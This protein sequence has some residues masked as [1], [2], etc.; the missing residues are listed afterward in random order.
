[1]SD[2]QR[3]AFIDLRV[4][5]HGLWILPIR[6][7]FQ[8][9][10]ESPAEHQNAAIALPKMLF[11]AIC[12]CALAGPCNEVLIHH[13]A[14]NPASGAG[15]LDCP[16]PRWNG[17]LLIGGSR[18]LGTRSKAHVTLSVFWSSIGTRHSK[19]LPVNNAF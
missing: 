17:S 10:E 3:N 4:A 13:V 16:I 11:G 19:W 5:D 15:I 8:F 14:G 12:N 18:S 7:A 2:R 9:I 6:D 1:M